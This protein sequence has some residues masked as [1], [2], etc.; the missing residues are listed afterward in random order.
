V[1]P[2]STDLGEQEHEGDPPGAGVG[3]GGAQI[4]EG[5]EDRAAYGL[6]QEHVEEEQGD[7]EEGG[8]RG[9]GAVGAREPSLE[10]DEDPGDEGEEEGGPEEEVEHRRGLRGAQ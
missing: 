4:G 8:P 3:D 2:I 6:H 7:A 9:D 1:G 10:R 5:V